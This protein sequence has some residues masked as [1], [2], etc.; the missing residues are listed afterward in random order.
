LRY[1]LVV[2]GEHPGEINPA[3]VDPD[4]PAVDHE[5]GHIGSGEPLYPPEAQDEGLEELLLG[6]FGHQVGRQE[7]VAPAKE[8]G[9]E[10]YPVLDR[11]RLAVD[12]DDFF[13]HTLD[14]V[15]NGLGGEFDRPRRDGKEPVEPSKGQGGG[16]R[17]DRPTRQKAKATL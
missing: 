10:Q 7:D 15:R 2:F 9:V 11:L 5:L 6:Q 14:K 8:P 1:G 3:V 12:I 16:R 13:F 17:V 4:A